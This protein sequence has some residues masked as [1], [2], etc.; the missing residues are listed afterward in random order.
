M[1]NDEDKISDEISLKVELVKS[2]NVYDIANA[3]TMEW[4]KRHGDETVERIKIDEGEVRRQ[5]ANKL[6]DAIVQRAIESMAR[7]GGY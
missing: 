7:E 6:V 1:I 3:V 4:M 5:A 2:K